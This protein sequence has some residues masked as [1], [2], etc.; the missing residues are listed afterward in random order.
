MERRLLPG[1]RT[2]YGAQRSCRDGRA[3][4]GTKQEAWSSPTRT[5]NYLL[6]K[7]KQSAHQECKKKKERKKTK[8]NIFQYHFSTVNIPYKTKEIHIPITRISYLIFETK[9]MVPQVSVYSL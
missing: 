7:E 8:K 3:S 4:T 9:I 5:C 6:I 1:L 2:Y